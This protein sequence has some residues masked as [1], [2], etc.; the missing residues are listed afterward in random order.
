[1]LKISNLKVNLEDKGNLKKIVA[2]KL[3]VKEESILELIILKESIDARKEVTLVYSLAIKINNPKSYL[4]YDNT[5]IYAPY[6]YDFTKIESEKTVNIVG[7]GPSGI[8]AAYML[9]K[10]NIKVNVFERGS[11]VESRSKQVDDFWHN[12]NLNTESNVQFGE[13]GAGT[14]SDGKLTTRIKDPRINLILDLFV[15]NGANKNITYEGYP[16]IGSDEL[17]KILINIRKELIKLNVSFY[18]DTKVTNLITKDNKVIGVIANELEYYS[19]KTILAIGHSSFDTI[20]NLAKQNLYIEPKDFAIGVRVEHPQDLINKNQY[21]EHYNHES[22]SAASYRLTHLSKENVGIYSFCMCPGGYVV[23]SSSDLN[24]IVTNGM[25]NSKRDN[26][27]ANSAILVQIPKKLFYKGSIFDG[28][29]FQKYYES[30]AYNLSNSYKAPAMNIKDYLENKVTPLIFKSSYLPETVTYNLNN[31][32]DDYINQAL[33]S[34]F[35]DFDKKIKGFIDNGIMIAPETRSSCTFRINRNK[36]LESV[37]H[38]N[39][40]PIGEG[41][42]YAGGIISSALDGIKTA[43]KII[44]IFK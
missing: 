27:Y 3:K 31:Y 19:D 18:F 7:Y 14:F 35:Y 38:L 16:H 33:K 44:S 29:N 10:S 20:E 21:K 26:I 37:S 13:G 34:A 25:S 36:E 11:I 30:K 24:T 28:I 9:A 32:F 6:K 22:L 41:A 43:E 8:L 23:N 1:M 5:S 42:G 39:L 4:K 2:K 12:N 15:S 17:K 40:Y